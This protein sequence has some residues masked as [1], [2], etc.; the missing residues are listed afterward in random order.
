MSALGQ[1]PTLI[2][3]RSRT[4]TADAEYFLDLFEYFVEGAGRL[5]RL[6]LVLQLNKIA[7][8]GN[9]TPRQNL[10]YLKQHNWVS[11]GQGSIGNMKLRVLRRPERPQYAVDL[12]TR[13]VR[14]K[15]PQ[16]PY[17]GNLDGIFRE[18]RPH[19]F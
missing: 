5:T 18:L 2:T 6:K 15:P 4:S 10:R 19:R 12:T 11:D 3:F 8:G 7:I 16:L 9:N 17:S 1:K 14:R 13:I